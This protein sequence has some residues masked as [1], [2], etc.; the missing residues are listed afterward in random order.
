[1]K[2]RQKISDKLKEL[3]DRALILSDRSNGKLDEV[4][5]VGYCNG[6][7][8]VELDLQ[9]LF[10]PELDQ[11]P[12]IESI[13][14]AYRL[15]KDRGWDTLYFAFDLHGTMI[16]PGRLKDLVVYPFVLETLQ[17]LSTQKD[18]VLILFTSTHESCLVPF[19]AWCKDNGITF[20]Y[21]NENPECFD[22]HEGDYSKKFYY[23][24]LFDDR[25]GWNPSTDWEILKNYING[26][27]K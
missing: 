27:L 7:K 8:E 9:N 21:F 26:I 13:K 17:L 11:P 16:E 3:Q 24:V 14:D 22:T 15:K 10:V 2:I 5:W 20:K 1:M 19:R 23:N 6:L 25:A 18:I 12:I 4:Y